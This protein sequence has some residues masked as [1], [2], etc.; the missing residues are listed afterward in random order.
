MKD[1]GLREPS[2]AKYSWSNQL[3]MHHLVSGA[4]WLVYGTSRS[5]GTCGLYGRRLCVTEPDAGHICSGCQRL[6]TTSFCRDCRLRSKLAAKALS[7]TKTSG[8]ASFPVVTGSGGLFLYACTG[9][10][11][12]MFYPDVVRERVAKMQRMQEV[13]IPQISVFFGHGYLPHAGEG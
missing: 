5:N 1:A 13:T 11:H 7:I 3:Y 10:H 9:S 2:A 6:E 4:A 8:L 12:F